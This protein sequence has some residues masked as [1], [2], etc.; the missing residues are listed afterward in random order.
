MA[1]KEDINL[2]VEPPKKRVVLNAP[3]VRSSIINRINR[4][5]TEDPEQQTFDLHLVPPLTMEVTKEEKIL[6]DV[7]P[8][9]TQVEVSRAVAAVITDDTGKEYV[10]STITWPT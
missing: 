10:I 7:V 8:D 9:S 2:L 6:V 1:I 4:L 5:A 3:P